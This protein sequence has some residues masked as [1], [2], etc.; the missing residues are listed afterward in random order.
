MT[1]SMPDKKSPTW[2]VVGGLIGLAIIGFIWVVLS[3]IWAAAATLIL[4][5]EGWTLRNSFKNDTISEVMWVLSNRPL[6]PFMFGGGVVAL[7]AH[8]VI[9]PNVQGLYTCL[10]LG[11][12]MGH[13]F[14]QRHEDAP[15]N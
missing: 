9:K 15:K 14:F 3:P 11:F 7:I 2:L 10:A 5:Y 13:F 6:V 8:D 4:M 12:L 1:F